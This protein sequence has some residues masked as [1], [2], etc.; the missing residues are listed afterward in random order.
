MVSSPHQKKKKK[1]KKKKKNENKILYFQT[2][3][4]MTPVLLVD[5][6]HFSSDAI[7]ST[8]FLFTLHYLQ[9]QFFF[10]TA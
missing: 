7:H 4:Q 9:I 1:I 10:M 8:L 2:S 6:S 5:K 3:S